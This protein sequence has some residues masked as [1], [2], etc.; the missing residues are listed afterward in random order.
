MVGI[1]YMGTKKQLSGPVA[2]AA[3][4]CRPGAF[5][6]LFSGMCAVGSSISG[7]RQ[8]WSND[9]QIFASE[10]A[11]ALFCSKHGPPHPFE[12]ADLA[13][14]TFRDNRAAVTTRFEGSLA[15]ECA[16]LEAASA[17]T[18]ARLF[19]EQLRARNRV[20]AAGMYDL[21]T[22]SFGGTFFG[23]AQSIEID[24]I[25]AAIDFL[26]DGKTISSDTHR[27]MLIALCVAMSKCSTTTGHFAQPLK[28]KPSNL[29]RFLSQRGR[30]PWREW[31]SALSVLAPL[32]S[33]IWRQRNRVFRRDA[34][35]LLKAL[36]HSKNRPC[37]IYADPPYTKDQYSRYYHVYET[38]ILYDYPT[39]SGRGQYREGRFTSAFSL[40]SKVDAAMNA[41]IKN[42]ALLE[43]DLIL[44]Y[45]SNGLLPDSQRRIPQLIAQH[46]GS[47][48]RIHKIKHL[49]STLGASK[50]AVKSAVTE[51]LYQVNA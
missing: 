1:G 34:V 43:C 39:Q 36:S 18:L 28:P 32:G 47:A 42:C 14:R 16:A 26:L 15:R 23:Y 8:V 51:V 5:L 44:S 31:L 45:P 7:S 35:A 33:S 6:D 37:V 29:R 13:F 40:A 46:Y 48:P 3:A 10:V 9:S 27:W 4:E 49:H 38:A 19:E 25:R 20:V 50:G 17:P 30:S 41:L 21:F 24:S 12:A 22:S 11:Q 2:A